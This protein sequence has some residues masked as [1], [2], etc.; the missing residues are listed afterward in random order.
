MDRDGSF[1]H[2]EG[3]FFRVVGLDVTSS[4]REVSVWHQPILDNPGTGI[5]G[6]L[7][8]VTDGERY[9]LMQAKAEPGNR[10]LVQIGPTVQFTPG[11]YIGNAKLPKPFLFDEF[12]RP[13]QF[14]LLYQST[15]SEEGARFY[16]ESHV[17][18][19]LTLPE[20]VELDPPA[21]FRWLSLATIH[22]CISLG[23]TVNSCAR[24][25]LALMLHE[26]MRR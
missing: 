9:F 2:E 16:Q 3:R 1:S 13:E 14:Q 23:E 24:S 15:Q 18:R 7:T 22:F 25:V 5:I 6:I 10:S 4:G 17:H 19:I 12:C 11:N 8:K 20:G 21:E 26:E